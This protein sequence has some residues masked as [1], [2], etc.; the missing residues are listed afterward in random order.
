MES[1]EEELCEW[2]GAVT[3]DRKELRRRTDVLIFEE[4]LELIRAEKEAV[5]V[6]FVASKS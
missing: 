6:V 1:V 3:P 5:P 2:A 4:T